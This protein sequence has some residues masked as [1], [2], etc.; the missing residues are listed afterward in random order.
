M[1][2]YTHCI[3][4]R[5]DGE[6]KNCRSSFYSFHLHPCQSSFDVSFFF[7]HSL[8]VSYV[9]EFVAFARRTFNNVSM[10]LRAYI[11]IFRCVWNLF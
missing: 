2:I 8:F 3:E 6:E 7:F 11:I 10:S 9:K 5:P 4:K 1:C